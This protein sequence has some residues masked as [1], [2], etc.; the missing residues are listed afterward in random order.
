M[1]NLKQQ[2]AGLRD[3]QKYQQSQDIVQLRNESNDHNWKKRYVQDMIYKQMEISQYQQACLHCFKQFSWNFIDTPEFKRLHDIKQLGTL[4]YVFP[5]ATHSR[6]SHSLGTGYLA[7]ESMK[8]LR[9]I[10][11]EDARYNQVYKKCQEAA[12]DIDDQDIRNVGLAGLMHDLGHGIY[13]HLQYGIKWEHEDASVMMLQHLVDQNH[14]DIEQD[15]LNFVS[16]LIKGD[17]PSQDHPKRWMFDIVANK[18]NSLDVDKFDYLQRD[19]KHMGIKTVGF[20]Y[21][22]I[23]K[24]SRVINGQLCYN[25]KIYYELAQVFHTRYKLFKDTYTHRVCKAIDYMIVDALLLANN[26]FKFQEKIFDPFAYTNLTDSVLSH[27]EMS[28]KPELRDSQKILKNLRERN[29]YRYIDQKLLVEKDLN[30]QI[31]AQEIVGYQDVSKFNVELRPE[32]IIVSFHTLNWGKGNE[33]PLNAV[34]FYRQNENDI[35][36]F[37][38]TRQEVGLCHPKVYQEHYLRV[39]VKDETKFDA[40]KHAFATMCK[41]YK[42]QLGENSFSPERGRLYASQRRLSQDNKAFL[43][44][45]SSAY[46]RENSLKLENLEAK[47]LQ[48]QQDI[49]DQDEFLNNGHNGNGSGNGLAAINKR[50]KFDQ[51]Q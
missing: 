43:S 34:R 45:N 44:Q 41:K 28:K 9:D 3:H 26:Y 17:V 6:F 50:L 16:K 48:S 39:F 27:I 12:L 30:K 4:Y 35:E 37:Y 19:S 40:A 36:T 11:V 13:S 22:R 20:D 15:D 1:E 51:K 42:H 5:G 33:N 24:N 10:A 49:W 2:Q 21:N 29:I 18:T 38:K 46:K 8:H 25:Q 14:I 47:L 23:I 31:T 32:D 7:T